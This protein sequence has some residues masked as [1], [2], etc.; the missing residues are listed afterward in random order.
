ME[1]ILK[2]RD[3]ERLTWDYDEEADV[4]YISFGEPRPAL[5]LDLGEG[6]LVRYQE[7]DGLMVGITIIGARE[8]LKTGVAPRPAGPK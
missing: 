3:T 8:M 4:L 2:L 5:A 7:E 1:T 6:V